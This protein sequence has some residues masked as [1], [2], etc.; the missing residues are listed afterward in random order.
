MSRRSG[1]L[2]LATPSEQGEIV[3]VQGQVVSA[4][5]SGAKTTV[6]RA[7]LEA[8]VIQPA[9]YQDLLARESQGERGLSLLATAGLDSEAAQNVLEQGLRAIV[10]ELFEWSEGTFSFVL[11]QDPEGWKNFLL[12]EPRYVLE[13][14]VNPQYLAIEGARLCDERNRADPLNAFLARDEADEAPLAVP[15]PVP[16]PIDA[17]P[18]ELEPMA[19]SLAGSVAA[20]TRW[21]V[22]VVDDDPEIAEAIRARVNPGFADVE[23]ATRVVDAI[24]V[25]DRGPLHDLILVT[26][27]ILPRSDERGILGGVQ[28]L[29]EARRRLVNL[30]VFVFSDYQSPDA[31]AR[32]RSMHV[33]AFLIKPRR[34]PAP[35]R[36]RDLANDAAFLV[37]LERLAGALAAFETPVA[38]GE[39]LAPAPVPELLSA[40]T[41]APAAEPSSGDNVDDLQA[42]VADSVGALVA[43]VDA[44]P[45]ATPMTE[46]RSELAALR[47]MLAELVNPANRETITLLVLRFASQFVERGALFLVTRRAFIGLGGFTQEDGSDAF[48]G[49]VRRIQVPIE[50]DSVFRRVLKYRSPVVA[51]LPDV[52]GNRLLLEGLGAWHSRA[53]VAAPIISGDR[54]AAVFLGDN[55]SGENLGATEGLEIF[56]QQAGLAMDRALLERRLEETRRR[57]GAS[58]GT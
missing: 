33:E 20:P 52:A 29:E 5:R 56:L 14:G 21:R 54:V 22:L 15:V 58:G 24:T 37:F 48:V 19:P 30:P 47:S 10:Y 53:V 26:D 27:L 41:P 39:P 6:G 31:E 57:D 9:A 38:P 42:A 49:R 43:D 8:G 28:L 55:P 50:Q 1:R 23:V 2:Q 40:P 35:G 46:A 7:L 16:D 4:Y 11:E 18:A 44:E 45:E 13:R 25:L 36:P 32:A 34:M 17:A 12:E 51:P 3:F